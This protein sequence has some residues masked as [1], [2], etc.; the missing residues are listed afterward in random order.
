MMQDYCKYDE[1]IVP[2]MWTS[3]SKE[4]LSYIFSCVYVVF[5]FL[6]PLCN[7][8]PSDGV[9]PTGHHPASHSLLVWT[10]NESCCWSLV[11]S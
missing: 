9:K 3:E 8:P 7:I 4:D 10:G 6:L 5:F 2:K 1:M 11:C